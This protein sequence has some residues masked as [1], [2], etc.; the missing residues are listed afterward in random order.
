MS[1]LEI[2]KQLLTYPGDTIEETIDT[3]SMS[4]AELAE[5]LGRTPKFINDLLKGDAHITQDLAI[6]LQYVLNIPAEGWIS[7]ERKYEDD[8]LA[9]K[10]EEFKQSCYEWVKRFPLSFLKKKGIIPKTKDKNVL[11]DK[12]LAFFRVATPD[13]WS[14]IYEDESLAFKIELRHATQP[15]AIS[16]WLR[17]GELDIQ[18]IQLASFDKKVLKNCIPSIQE[19]SYSMPEDWAQ[20]LKNICASFGVALSLS[21]IMPKAPIYGAARWIQNKTVPLIQVTDRRKNIN[22]FW[23]SFYHE[24]GH[25]YLHGKK[26]I[27]LEGID[28]IELD[29]E[30]ENQ[31]DKFA[32]NLLMPNKLRRELEKYQTLR[33]LDVKHL[34]KKYKVNPGIIVEQAKRMKIIAYNNPQFKNFMTKIEF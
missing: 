18:D 34:S 7:L 19:L 5:R 24:L 30:K 15:E 33:I 9:I 17:L 6:K 23:F 1:T 13:E 2:K 29:Q 26:D 28:E 11:V 8:L 27:F 3:I 22:S 21:P 20:Q 31:A 10:K 14:K 12:L 32:S 25:I 16:T 4:K